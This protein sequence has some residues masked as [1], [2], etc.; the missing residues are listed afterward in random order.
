LK[1]DEEHFKHYSNFA[2]NSFKNELLNFWAA[3]VSLFLSSWNYHS[4]GID[5]FWRDEIML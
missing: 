4:C 2:L 3:G 5:S 1:F